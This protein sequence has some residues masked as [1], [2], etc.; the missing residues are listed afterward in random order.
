[1]AGRI[2]SHR[3]ALRHGATIAM[4][5]LSVCVIATMVLLGGLEAYLRLSIPGSSNESIYE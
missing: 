3:S 2:G 4:V 1:V 5:N